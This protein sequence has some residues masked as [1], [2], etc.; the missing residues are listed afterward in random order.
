MDGLND[1]RD[2]V[3]LGVG[4]GK[5]EAISMLIDAER[6]ASKIHGNGAEIVEG[7]LHQY[8]LVHPLPCHLDQML[9]VLPR[10]LLTAPCFVHEALN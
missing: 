8:I 9:D 4:M 2:H 6:N 1:E 10:I 3:F 7:L 5:A